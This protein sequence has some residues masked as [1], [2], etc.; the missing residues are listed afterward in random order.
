M[1]EY[2]WACKPPFCVALDVGMDTLRWLGAAN[3]R[4][5]FAPSMAPVGQIDSCHTESEKLGRTHMLSYAPFQ[6]RG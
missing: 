1:S 3:P 2:R 5:W 4:F 6:G